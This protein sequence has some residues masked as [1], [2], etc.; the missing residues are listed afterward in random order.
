MREEVGSKKILLNEIFAFGKC[1]MCFAHEI[2]AFG[3]C[4]IFAEGECDSDFCLLL[5]KRMICC[6]AT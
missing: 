3:R 4:E 6:C 1:E 2:S 5:R